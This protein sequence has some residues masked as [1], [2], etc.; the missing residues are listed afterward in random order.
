MPKNSICLAV[1]V[2]NQ[3]TQP[4]EYA[5]HMLF[6]YYPFRNENDLKSGNPPTYS[7]KL[8][9]S[10]VISLVNQ[11]RARVEPFATIIDDAF[12]RYTSELE[13]NMDPFGQQDNDETYEEQCQQLEQANAGNYEEINNEIEG[14][15]YPTQVNQSTYKQT[16][17]FTDDVISEHIRSLNDEQRKVFDVLHKWSRDYIKSLRSKTIQILNPFHLFITGGGGVG[18]SHLI[19]TIYM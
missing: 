9:E 17:F 12:E 19:K 3:Q 16:P 10:N 2:S 1:Y 15:M 8:R 7:N 5:H 18:K 4:E 11:N 6:M 14:E 13:T